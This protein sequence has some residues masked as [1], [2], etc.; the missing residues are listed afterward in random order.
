MRYK[1]TREI[2]IDQWN[3]FYSPRFIQ[4]RLNPDFHV[5]KYFICYFYLSNLK[6]R[7]ISSFYAVQC[8]SGCKLMDV[9]LILYACSYRANR[10]VSKCLKHIL[11]KLKNRNSYDPVNNILDVIIDNII[12]AILIFL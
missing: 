7:R 4:A 5:M 9:P 11:S 2:D 6:D 10:L 3:L 8:T 1:N 12:M